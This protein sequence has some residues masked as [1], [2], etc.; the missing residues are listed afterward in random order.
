M[1]WLIRIV[2]AV[3]VIGVA[4][5]AIG[6][7]FLPRTVAVSR[8]IVIDA[9]VAT[10]W[11]LVSN[12]RVLNDWQPWAAYDPQGTKYT[13]EGPELGVGQVMNWRSDHPNVG[14]GRQEVI[15]MQTERSVTTRLD[16]GDM[17]TA[18]ASMVLDPDG[19]RTRAT[20]DFKTDLGMDPLARW[21]GL[22]FDSWVGND[23]DKGLQNL[24]TLAEK[25]AR[26]G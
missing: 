15:A 5:T 8:S 21:F 23:Y 16:F 25:K 18:E 24:K 19:E 17:G 11:P 20:W 12:L 14:T 9:P 7:I 26:E 22:M 13:Y 2:A 3:L 6:L 10:V 1:R 4:L